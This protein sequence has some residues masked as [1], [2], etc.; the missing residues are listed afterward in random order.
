MTWPV[1]TPCRVDDPP[2]VAFRIAS[3]PVPRPGDD[4][5]QAVMYFIKSVDGEQGFYIDEEDLQP[6]DESGFCE[7]GKIGCDQGDPDPGGELLT[8]ALVA[9][10]SEKERARAIDKDSI[11]RR[12]LEQG[13]F[14]GFSITRTPSGPLFQCQADGLFSP[15]EVQYMERL[16]KG[17][18]P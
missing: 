12:L 18:E 17:D 7:C 5:P 8:V 1:D 13:Q 10:E 3:T 4:D 16:I 9:A 2:G 6:L 14:R 11:I 15:G